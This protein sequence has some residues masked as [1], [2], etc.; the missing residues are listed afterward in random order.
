LQH[1]LEEKCC[2]L[3]FP[4]SATILNEKLAMDKENG[5]IYFFTAT[6][7]VYSRMLTERTRYNKD[8][9]LPC[10]NRID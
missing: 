10:R 7:P 6:G 2:K 4:K 5:H 3:T 8:D 9:M 1:K